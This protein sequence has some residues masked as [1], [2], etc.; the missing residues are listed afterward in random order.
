VR[1]EAAGGGLNDEQQ[2][3]LVAHRSAMERRRL[4]RQKDSANLATL[5]Q[6]EVAGVV[7]NDKER[8]QLEVLRSA[9]NRKDESNRKQQL[10]TRMNRF[11]QFKSLFIDKEFDFAQLVRPIDRN[12]IKHFI[13]SEWKRSVSMSESARTSS[14]DLVDQFFVETGFLFE[15]FFETLAAKEQEDMGAAR[16]AEERQAADKRLE[17][18]ERQAA[19]KRKRLEDAE[20]KRLEAEKSKEERQAA[21]KRKR[22]EDAETKRLEA[23]KRKVIIADRGTNR[24]L[25]LEMVDKETGLT[26]FSYSCTSNKDMEKKLFEFGL[27]G[28]PSTAKRHLAKYIMEA[29]LHPYAPINMYNKVARLSIVRV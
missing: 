4:K 12:S 3:R 15:T 26:T 21:N 24:K 13:R 7:L 16:E 19:K 10:M 8:V 23:E 28:T 22:L 25:T 6:L 1:L 20:T 11:E 29:N 18:E 17:A 2:A 14:S 5:E 9:K 27:A